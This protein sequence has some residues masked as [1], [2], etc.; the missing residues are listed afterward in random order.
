VIALGALACEN[1]LPGTA[2]AKLKPGD[3]F[4]P[5]AFTPNGDGKNDIFK[6]EGSM[7][8]IN[9]KIFNQWG[10]LIAETSIVGDGWNG[11]SGGK[12]QPSG[13]YMYAIK[14]V[15]NDGSSVVK[16]GALNLLR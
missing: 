7:K 1:S 2:T 6:P 9:M 11:T 5:N 15:L 14:V 3:V 4:V 16:K 12:V 8:A 13:V 10:E